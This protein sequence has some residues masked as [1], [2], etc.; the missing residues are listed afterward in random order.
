MKVDVRT[1]AIM[2]KHF[3]L[4]FSANLKTMAGTAFM[5]SC[6]LFYVLMTDWIKVHCLCS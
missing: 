2:V 1:T 3:N 4:Y 6:G 5:F